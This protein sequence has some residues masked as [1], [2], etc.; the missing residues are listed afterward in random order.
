MSLVIPEPV[1]WAP[2]VQT[3]PSISTATW[4]SGQAK[5]NLQLLLL[6][7]LCSLTG[8]GSFSALTWRANA[9]SRWLKLPVKRFEDR[10][11]LFVLG[12]GIGHLSGDLPM[13]IRICLSNGS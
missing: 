10:H 6:W 2:L 13:A 12:L 1:E 11:E 5:S 9:S 7:N 8:A 3:P 4:R